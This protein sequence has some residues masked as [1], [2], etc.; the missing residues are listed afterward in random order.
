MKDQLEKRIVEFV[1]IKN[2]NLEEGKT[3][4]PPHRDVIRENNASTKLLILYDSSV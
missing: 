1:N 4:Y 2:K 3:I